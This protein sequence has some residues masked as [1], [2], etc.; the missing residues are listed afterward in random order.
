M[1]SAVA[2]RKAAQAARQEN[3]VPVEQRPVASPSPVET[4][5]PTKPT[6]KR[7][8]TT[9]PSNAPKRKKKEKRTPA[10]RTVRYFVEQ[11][12]LDSFRDQED[13]IV[14]DSDEEVMSDEPEVPVVVVDKRRW[15]PSIPLNDSSDE[16]EEGPS[17]GSSMTPIPPA[18]VDAPQVLS[19][20]QPTLNQNMFLLEPAH[21]SA[22]NVESTSNASGSVVLLGPSDTICLLGV[23]TFTV[24]QG[25]ITICGVTLSASLRTFRVFAPRSSPLPVLEG[26]DGI[27]AVP[28]INSLPKPLHT[29]I[30]SPVSLVLFQELRTGVEGLGHVCRTFDSVF[31]PSRWQKAAGTS[32]S[33]QLHGVHMITHQTKDVQAFDLPYSWER[34]LSS[35]SSDAPVGIHLVKGPKKSGK[36]TFARTLVNRLLTQYRRVAYL[37]CDLGQ[38]EFT[39]GGMVALNVVDTPLF[40]PPFTHLTLPTF[41]HY[42]GATTPRSS[43][44]HYLT[45]VQSA[46]ESYRLDI[47]TP[48]VAFDAPEDDTRISGVIPLVVNTMGWNKGLGADLTTKIQDTTEPTDIYEVEAPVFDAVWPAPPP[49]NPLPTPHTAKLHPLQ[50]IASSVLSTSYSAADHRSLAILSYFHA[51]FPSSPPTELEQVTAT[52]W[53]TSLP[54][55]ARPPYEV[56]CAQVF[57]K[58]ILTGAGSEDVVPSEVQR[59]LNGAVV[60][61]VACEPGTLD[62]DVSM[63]STSTDA[64]PYTQ[65]FPVP[66]PSTSVC[67]GLALIRSMS[68]ASS[69]MHILTPLPHQALAKCRVVVKGELDLPVWGMLDFRGDGDDVAGVEKGRVPYLQW[70]KGEGVGAERRRVRRNLMRRGQM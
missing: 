27:G 41:A 12:Q 13:V 59:V 34:A 60:G 36:S 44:S 8:P 18:K 67:H 21:I 65:G 14:I 1:L 5:P 63:S 46:L 32:A 68:P 15:S 48:A 64:I 23:Y 30:G 52:T 62:L 61:L 4:P 56:D 24:L 40:G 29:V 50:P 55:C 35:A 31:E 3:A 26:V 53:N 43:P 20:F 11:E 17:V 42:I 37:E 70:G 66:S 10:V 28:S 47:Q 54:L 22:L 6:S 7:K 38:S 58:V 9:Q 19:I 2:A 45:A 16:D 33:L 51:V 69:Q 57:E 39:P 49:R 25:S